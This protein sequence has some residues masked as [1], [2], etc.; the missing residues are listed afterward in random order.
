MEISIPP[1][2]NTKVTPMAAIIKYALSLNK[3]RKVDRE[4][5]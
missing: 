3:L 1:V 2:N 5:K 4:K